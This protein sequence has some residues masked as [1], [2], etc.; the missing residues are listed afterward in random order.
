MLYYR[1]RPGQTL[2]DVLGL[3]VQ[4]RPR[5][6]PVQPKDL[7]TIPDPAAAAA[8]AAAA[9]READLEPEAKAKLAVESKSTTAAADGKA[10]EAKTESKAA[11]EGGVDA[12]K[13]ATALHLLTRTLLSQPKVSVN[14]RVVIVGSSNTALSLLETLL[15]VPDLNYSN[16][17]LLSKQGAQ[18]CT[19]VS[20]LRCDRVLIPSPSLQACGATVTRRRLRRLLPP[21]SCRGGPTLT[22]VTCVACP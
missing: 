18:G 14:A 5:R 11:G 22:S 13:Q 8:A 20:L 21:R 17:T 3:F 9:E 7:I 16:I 1:V 2:Q 12:D 10:A 6:R 19:I 4:V 15:L